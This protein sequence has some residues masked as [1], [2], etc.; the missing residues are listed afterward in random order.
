MVSV[1]HLVKAVDLLIL[2]ALKLMKITMSVDY[3]DDW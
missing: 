1:H 3:F 2:R